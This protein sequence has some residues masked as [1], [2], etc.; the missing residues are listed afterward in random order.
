MSWLQALLHGQVSYKIPEII[1]V[2]AG[3]AVGTGFLL[4]GQDGDDRV[5]RDFLVQN[6]HQRRIR[7]HPVVV[8]VAA[9]HAPVKADIRHLERR[10]QLQ[11]G[12]KKIILS[13]AVLFVQ[14]L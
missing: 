13:D 5:I 14:E 3:V 4:V 1:R 9:D 2:Q 7:A 11:L 6:S 12:G 8:A 10:H